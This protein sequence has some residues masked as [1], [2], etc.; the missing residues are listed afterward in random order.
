MLVGAA[1]AAARLALAQSLGY[2]RRHVMLTAEIDSRDDAYR[3]LMHFLASQGVCRTGTRQQCRSP[4]ACVNARTAD[5]AAAAALHCCCCLPAARHV[6]TRDGAVGDNQLDIIR[7]RSGT[8]AAA[9]AC[10][11]GGAWRRRRQQRASVVPA[12]PRLTHI[13]LQR[14][15]DVAQQAARH[16]QP[17][18]GGQRAVRH[19]CVQLC[20]HAA[21]CRLRAQAAQSS[22]CCQ[23]VHE[24]C[25]NG[26]FA[27]LAYRYAGG[28]A[29][30]CRLLLETLR[31]SMLG[32]S[33]WH[34]DQLLAD[35][36]AAYQTSQSS[37]TIV[38]SVDA[39]RAAP[40]TH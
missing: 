29:P 21:C 19:A 3:W 7:H 31:I 2:L 6:S 34:L 27:A 9:V 16:R 33:R 26:A 32:T 17:A 30:P 10:S 13:E 8:A 40:Q 39:V 23:A 22:A 37:R 18:V 4:C 1:A 12:G 36:A 11:G 38:H 28:R 35:A 15:A 25:R 5:I 20:M 14:Q 24:D